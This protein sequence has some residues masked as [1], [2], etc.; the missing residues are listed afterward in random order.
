MDR[1]LVKLTHDTGDNDELL[2]EVAAENPEGFTPREVR[3]LQVRFN[4]NVAL[5]NRG[6]KH[7]R[8]DMF[9]DM[10]DDEYLQSKLTWQRQDGKEIADAALIQN[11]LVTSLKAV[12]NLH[13]KRPEMDLSSLRKAVDKLADHSS[14]IVKTEAKKLQKALDAN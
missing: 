5:A 9:A 4:A 14:E 3:A 7:V 12:G 2:A 1:L 10:L 6:S 13:K 11:T 8:L